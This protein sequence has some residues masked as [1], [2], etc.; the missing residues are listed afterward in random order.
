MGSQRKTVRQFKTE[1]AQLTLRVSV[2]LEQRENAIMFMIQSMKR[3]ASQRTNRY[4]VKCKNRCVTL[5]IDSNAKVLMNRN[6]ILS[7]TLS[8]NKN[9]Q[10]SMNKSAILSMKK[11]VKLLSHLMEEGEVLHQGMELLL[12]LLV[13]GSQNKSVIMSQRSS[14]RMS[15]DK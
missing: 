8:M 2:L 14:A 15:Q 13:K 7:M 3:S 1:N 11:F 10:L 6:A 12:L 5:S 4:A 9:V